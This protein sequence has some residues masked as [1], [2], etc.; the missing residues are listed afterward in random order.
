MQYGLVA[1]LVE[2]RTENPRVGSSILSQATIRINSLGHLHRCPFLVWC[3]IGVFYLLF[4]ISSGEL[5]V[6][7]FTALL[8]VFEVILFASKGLSKSVMFETLSFNHFS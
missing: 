5:L 8:T 1:Q 3:I 7:V 6:G 2:Q 4:K